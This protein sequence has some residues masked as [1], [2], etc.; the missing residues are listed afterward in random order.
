MRRDIVDGETK[1]AWRDNWKDHSIDEIMTIFKYPRV[2]KLLDIFVSLLPRGGKIIEGGCGLGPWVIKLTSLGYNVT[3]VDYDEA[4]IAKIRTGH[5]GIPLYVAN[6]EAM[7]FDDGIFD[8]YMSLGVL[9]HFSEGPDKAVKEAYR[10]LADN[11]SFIIMLPYPNLLEIAKM[12][13]KK[14]QKSKMLRKVLGKPEKNFYYERY[15]R[16]KEMTRILEKNG[17]VV[18]KAMPIDHIFTLV[19]FSG[20]FRDKNT[21]D[22]ENALAVKCADFLSKVLPWQ[23]A[24]SSLIVARKK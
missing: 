4:S 11:G 6:I 19:S 16:V 18:E 22:G 10:V 3:G 8:A 17:F 1:Q 23:T 14:M 24:G 21:Y 15:F 5:G 7:P 20:I 9:E 2:K 13:F 12:P